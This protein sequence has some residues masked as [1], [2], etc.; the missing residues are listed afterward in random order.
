MISIKLEDEIKETSVKRKT[1]CPVW[2]ES[3][4]LYEI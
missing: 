1:N 4:D 3:F 2:N